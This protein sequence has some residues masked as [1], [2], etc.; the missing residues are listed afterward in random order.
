MPEQ[1]Q[2]T[3]PEARLVLQAIKNVGTAGGVLS[4]PPITLEMIGP[5]QTHV[6]H[7]EIDLQDLEI[8]APA[9]YPERIS[10]G[11]KRDQLIQI[12]C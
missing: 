3:E 12:W 7:S 9:A 8:V 2:W 1:L 10:S 4:L 6:L 5:I 11:S